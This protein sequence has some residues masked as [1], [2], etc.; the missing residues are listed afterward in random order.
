MAAGC[1]GEIVG[2]R[3]DFG[4]Q[5]NTHT[6]CRLALHCMCRVGSIDGKR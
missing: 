2:V 1:I 5:V 6:V 4:F 3:G